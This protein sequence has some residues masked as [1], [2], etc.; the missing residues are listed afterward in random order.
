MTHSLIKI[1]LSFVAL[2]AVFDT[3]WAYLNS[4][5]MHL[6][7]QQIFMLEWPYYLI[8]LA[9]GQLSAHFSSSCWSWNY[10]CHPMGLK[11]R[12]DSGKRWRLSPGCYA[13]FIFLNYVIGTLD[14]SVKISLRNKG[15]RAIQSTNLWRG[16]SKGIRFLRVNAVYLGNCTVS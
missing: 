1:C 12:E 11:S 13:I 5:L 6:I 4:Q 15:P 7:E 8:W 3:E 14:S 10:L 9:N 16:L 2:K